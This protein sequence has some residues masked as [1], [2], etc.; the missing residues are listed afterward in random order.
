[1]LCTKFQEASIDTELLMRFLMQAKGSESKGFF[2]QNWCGRA[3]RLS[4][5]FYYKTYK[6]IYL[7]SVLFLFFRMGACLHVGQTCMRYR[8]RI[9]DI[10]P[11]LVT[12]NKGYL[13]KRKCHSDCRKEQ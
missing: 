13:S 11:G 1:M 6:K 10:S 3:L 5:L 4:T 9:S 7:S 12:N 2:K 8:K